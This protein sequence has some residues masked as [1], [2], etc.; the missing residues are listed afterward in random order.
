MKDPEFMAELRRAGSNSAPMAGEELQKLVAD[1][2]AVPPAIVDK[3]KTLYPL[4]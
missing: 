3:V 2:G 4:N 1:L